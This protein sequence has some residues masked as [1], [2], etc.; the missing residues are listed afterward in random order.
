MAYCNH[1][2]W[3]REC[4]FCIFQVAKVGLHHKGLAARFGRVDSQYVA[5][6]PDCRTCRPSVAQTVAK[7]NVTVFS[8]V[9]VEVEIAFGDKHVDASGHQ[10]IGV[11]E[12]LPECSGAEVEHCTPVFRY[13]FHSFFVFAAFGNCLQHIVAEEC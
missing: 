5:C 10:G 12:F 13:H 9:S 1:S 6:E 3:G 2:I 4:A 7:A 8:S 11:Y